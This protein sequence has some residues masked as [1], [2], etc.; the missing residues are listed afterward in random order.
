MAVVLDDPAD[1]HREIA[2]AVDRPRCASRKPR[3]VMTSSSTNTTTSPVAAAMPALRARRP[4]GVGPSRYTPGNAATAA[5]SR[6]DAASSRLLSTT[7]T[8]YRSCG[9]VWSNRAPS[10][11]VDRGPLRRTT[12][13]RRCTGVRSFD[14]DPS[15]SWASTGRTLEPRPPRRDEIR[16]LLDARLLPSTTRTHPTRPTSATRWNEETW[17]RRHEPT[18]DR[19]GGVLGRRLRDEYASRNIGDQLL[20]S[21]VQFFTAPSAQLGG[22]VVCGVRRQHRH[23]PARTQDALPGNPSGGSKSTPNAADSWRPY[24][25]GKRVSGSIFD[26]PAGRS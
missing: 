19:P 8:S 22:S 23:E 17:R 3:R 1:T 2:L 18:S 20:A 26:L 25:Q 4:A 21:N 11:R 24:R 10:V 15:W 14:S 16:L 9:R 7:T 6:T 12:G 5:A 13:S